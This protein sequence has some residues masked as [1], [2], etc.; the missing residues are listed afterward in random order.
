M[1]TVLLV[2]HGQ[3]SF[4]AADYDVLSE[5]GRRRAEIAAASL[6]ERGEVDLGGAVDDPGVV[7]A[8]TRRRDDGA[9]VSAGGRVLSP[10]A[11]GGTLAEARDRAY[12]LLDRLDLPGG[13]ARRDI[14]LRAVSGELGG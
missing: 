14:A 10:T 13:H 2:R 6:A 3:A 12:A 4:G 9:V 5:T 11:V 1:P 8:G 7:H